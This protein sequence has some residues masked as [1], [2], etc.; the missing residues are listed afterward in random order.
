MS[1]E[2]ENN[3]YQILFD[4]LCLFYKIMQL[5]SIGIRKLNLDGTLQLDSDGNPMLTYENSDIAE[6]A[7]VYTGLSRREMRSNIET[8][9][10]PGQFRNNQGNKYRY[11]YVLFKCKIR[12]N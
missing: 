6:Y 2:A 9:Q 5:F 1:E 8:A 7:K 3:A 4:R 12:R 11:V 10:H